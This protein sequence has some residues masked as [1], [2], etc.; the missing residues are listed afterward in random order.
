MVAGDERR[1]RDRP[2]QR[3]RHDLAAAGRDRAYGTATRAL[4]L[5]R[6]DL[7]GKTGTTNE[8]VDAWFCGYNAAMVGVAWIG[9]DQPRTLG[10]NE[11]GGVAALPI[12]IAYMQKALKGTPERAS[13]RCPTASSSRA[14][15]SRNRAARRRRQLS[16]S[17]SSRS[18]RRAAATK[19][20]VPGLPGSRHATSATSS[21]DAGA[22]APAGELLMRERD[23]PPAA[24]ADIRAPRSLRASTLARDRARI[25]QAAARLIAE[26]GIDRLVARQAQGRAAADA[27]RSTPRCRRNDE[28]EAALVEYHALFGG[29]AHAAEPAGAAR[30]RAR[31]DAAP[32]R[33]VAAARR[34]R[35]GRLGD[36]AQRH[37]ARTR[38]RRRRRRSRSL[39]AGDGVAYAAVGSA[40]KRRAAT[41]T[42][43]ADRRPASAPSG[44]EVVTPETTGATATRQRRSRVAARRRAAAG[45]RCSTPP[46]REAA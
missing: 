1:A 31:L 10:A 22:R 19:A 30:E 12:W 14:D 35:R 20:S 24:P 11:T 33:V 2:A 34:R 41:A 18:S 36:R 15:Q 46:A 13:C 5:G 26:H 17:T 7:A 32:R 42:A 39:L 28:I 29:D 9:F 21:S 44:C 23:L 27:A 40:G 43:A 16:A 4:S 6:S 38:R 25:A 3:V 45:R 37:P 8:N